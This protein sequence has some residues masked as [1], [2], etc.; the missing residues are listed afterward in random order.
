MVRYDLKQLFIGGEGSLG[1]VTGVALLC[2]PRWASVDVAYLA[3]ADWEATQKVGQPP[4]SA[5][6]STLPPC[7]HPDNPVPVAARGCG[8]W[9]KALFSFCPCDTIWQGVMPQGFEVTLPPQ[10]ST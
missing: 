1:V 3:C 6:S 5:S 9:S 7:F 8:V 2:A 10:L 4:A